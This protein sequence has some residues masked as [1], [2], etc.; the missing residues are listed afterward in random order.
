MSNLTYVSKYLEGAVPSQLSQFHWPT[1][2]SASKQVIAQNDI[3]YSLAKSECEA[4][5][6]LDLQLPLIPLIMLSYYT[7]CVQCL[8]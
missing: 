6:L 2:K 1:W 4:L 7:G 5:T 3:H 8:V